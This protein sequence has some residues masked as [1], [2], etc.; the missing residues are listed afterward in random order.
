ME[1]QATVPRRGEF[2]SYA[3][4]DFFKDSK[5]NN[6][7]EFYGVGQ[8]ESLD[9]GYSPFHAGRQNESGAQTLTKRPWMGIR[10]G[11]DWSPASSTYTPSLTP[12]GA[13]TDVSYPV[14]AATSR[15]RT[16]QLPQS[17]VQ[18]IKHVV[19]DPNTLTEERIAMMKLK[20]ENEELRRMC[21]EL[22]NVVD[23]TVER[24]QHVSEDAQCVASMAR[25][26]AAW[27]AAQ[28]ENQNLLQGDHLPL[29]FPAEV[30][31]PA[32]ENSEFSRKAGDDNR[33]RTADVLRVDTNAS[34]SD[35][36]LHYKASH[37]LALLCTR[38]RKPTT[39]R[40]KSQTSSVG[41][42]TPRDCLR[43]GTASFTPRLSTPR[44]EIGH[45][46]MARQILTPCSNRYQIVE[47]RNTSALGTDRPA[48]AQSRTEHGNMPHALSPAKLQPHFGQ[49][50]AQSRASTA[51]SARMK[52]QVRL[53]PLLPLKHDLEKTCH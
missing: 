48:T 41:F 18:I 22:Q 14:T 38:Q 43:P 44:S 12:S 30:E 26:I 24:A 13:H 35:R 4:P 11:H 3:R 37:P 32:H 27:Q 19:A 40:V 50:T 23:L 20:S 21:S 9:E 36:E 33:T 17:P 2:L 8:H 34:Q 46:G 31:E 28:E 16:A 53:V 15:P 6:L 42:H 49:P 39:P 51:S 25:K 7:R 29:D 47:K 45:A 52:R 1:I 5:I 10:E